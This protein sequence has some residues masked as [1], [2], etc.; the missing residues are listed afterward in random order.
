M[1]LKSMARRI[2]ARPVVGYIV[3]FLVTVPITT[4]YMLFLFTLW[5]RL[6]P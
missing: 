6:F 5:Q 1:R 2:L 3:I 4:L